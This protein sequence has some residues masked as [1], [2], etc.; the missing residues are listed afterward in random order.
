MSNKAEEANKEVDN[1]YSAKKEP[2]QQPNSARTFNNT[3]VPKKKVE[4]KA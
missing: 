2:V 3:F 1:P 4:E